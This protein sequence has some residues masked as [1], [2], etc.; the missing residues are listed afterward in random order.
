MA[1]EE[2]R[3]VSTNMDLRRH[4][5]GRV[6]QATR[7]YPYEANEAHRSQIALALKTIRDWIGGGAEYKPLRLL[8]SG[9]AGAGKSFVIHALADLVRKLLGFPG[10]AMVY[11]RNRC[12][13]V[14]GGWIDGAQPPPT[15][16]REEDFRPARAVEGRIDAKSEGKFKVARSAYRR[17]TRDDRA[18]YARA[19]GV[20]C[21]DRPNLTRIPF[22]RATGR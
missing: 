9:V 3:T 19:A 11:A 18:A 16:N 2:S 4:A 12:R 1:P 13:G 5:R 17:R 8:T 20:Q 14:P 15:P 7:Y 10:S 22:C 21:R 6:P